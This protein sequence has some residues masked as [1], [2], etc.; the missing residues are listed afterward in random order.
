MIVSQLVFNRFYFIILVIFLHLYAYFTWLGQGF[1]SFS[2]L[3]ISLSSAVITISIKEKCNI[4]F[5]IIYIISLV[6]LLS[7]SFSTN[8]GWYS[9]LQLLASSLIF[10]AVYSCINQS[11]NNMKIV[12]FHCVFNVLFLFLLWVCQGF[13]SFKPWLLVNLNPN[14]LGFFIFLNLYFI[15][16]LYFYTKNFYIK[17]ISLVVVVLSIVLIFVS[18]SRASL[19]ALFLS[20][21]L[22]FFINNMSIRHNA[23]LCGLFAIFVFMPLVAYFYVYL[24][25][26]SFSQEL[27][28]LIWDKTGKSLFTG[29]SE[30]WFV[31]FNYI[32][33]NFIFGAGFGADLSSL[34]IDM[35]S[36]NLYLMLM[37]Q[38]GIIGY[39]IFILYFFF[40]TKVFSRNKYLNDDKISNVS[41]IW[42]FSILFHQGFELFLFQNNLAAS[43]LF[44][45]I[46]CIPFSENK[47]LGRV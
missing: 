6:L 8:L 39:F 26:A 21:L 38:L 34:N 35:S 40:M 47:I 25:T 30:I 44:W 20:F 12:L 22:F 42:V 41:V 17:F 5:L 31:I 15:I 11:P 45:F 10:F 33:D 23:Y 29:R 43:F 1:L 37:Y 7:L 2:A 28:Q 3:I 24:S 16:V 13:V 19:L 14:V 18:G 4:P 9:F 36:H 27:N 32:C 46:F